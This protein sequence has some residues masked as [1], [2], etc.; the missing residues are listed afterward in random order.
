[1]TSAIAERLQRLSLRCNRLVE[2]GVGLLS[3]T[4]TVVVVAQVFSRY[5]FNHSLFW[6]EE[7]ARYLLVWLTFLGSTV[8]YFRFAH[9]AINL[10]TSRCTPA[11]RQMFFRLRLLL[12]AFFFFSLLFYGCHFAW[13]VRLQTTPALGLPKWLIFVSVPLCALLL[14]LHALAMGLK[15]VSEETG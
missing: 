6:S 4:M 2:F 14:L 11:I 1:M 3:L 12:E 9:P 7:L 15:A 5:L 13:F 8:A 10:F